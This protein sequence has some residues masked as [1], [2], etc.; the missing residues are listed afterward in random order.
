MSTT[1]ADTPSK[2]TGGFML[3][4]ISSFAISLLGLMI[5]IISLPVD[6]WIRGFLAVTA[7]FLVSSTITISKVVR[8]REEATVVYRRIDQA[9][10]EK[11]LADYDPLREV[12][13]AGPAGPPMG[14]HPVGP[15]P[16]SR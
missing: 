14:P 10:L 9:R 4:A 15:P 5:G 7:L 1:T 2:S 12:S 13:F 6:P 8:D 11:V 3:Q 16:Q